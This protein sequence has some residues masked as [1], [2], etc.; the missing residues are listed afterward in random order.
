MIEVVD[1]LE[2]SGAAGILLG[3]YLMERKSYWAPVCLL[4]GASLFAFFG[5][6]IEAWGVVVTN[7]G[8]AALSLRTFLTW[9]KEG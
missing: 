2:W 1:V 4:I 3:L 5:V 9:R 8:S 7:L 6:M